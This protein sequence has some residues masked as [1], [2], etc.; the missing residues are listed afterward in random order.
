MNKIGWIALSLVKG[1]GNARFVELIE[2]FS[3]P[4]RVFEANFKALTRYVPKRVAVEIKK[5]EVIEQA[6]KVVKECEKKGIE[7]VPMNSPCYP[8]LLRHI[9]DPPSVL[10]LKGEMP[11]GV[12]I[13]VVGT[14]HPTSYGKM[15]AEKISELIALNGAVV[16]S[17][18]A[19]GIDAIAHAT[20]LRCGGKTVA[21]LGS[22][23]DVIYPAEH[24]SLFSR[25]AKNGAVIS[26]YPPGEPP[27]SGHFPKRNRII[28]ALS[29]AVVV[30][31][32]GEKS[33]AI[34][35]A[36]CALEQGRDVYAVPGPI[37]SP[38]SRGTNSLIKE[39]ATPITKPE[40]ILEIM[41][42]SVCIYDKKYEKVTDDE[43]KI[44]NLFNEMEIGIDEIVEKT[45]LDIKR[46]SSILTSLELKGRIKRTQRGYIKS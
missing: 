2:A 38:K 22:G 10:Y 13:A 15:V 25:I 46:V 12:F 17:G 35:T 40:D 8:E 23:V 37:T 34:I 24:T 20:S 32:A 28:S 26:E 1:I 41:G 39:G 30:V 11:R 18:L 14:R 6:K 42:Y 33:G 31:E 3:A 5:K 36:R 9:P 21:V 29:K 7:V 16:I 19:Y 4:E 44:L 27:N 45:E 43:E